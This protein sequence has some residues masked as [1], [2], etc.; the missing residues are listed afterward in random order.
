MTKTMYLIKSDSEKDRTQFCSNVESIVVSMATRQDI[1]GLKYTIT[2]QQPPKLTV[3]PFHQGLLASISVYGS[4]GA[5]ETGLQEMPGFV[6]AFEVEEAYPIAYDKTW[7]DNEPTPG[8]NL[9][10]LFKKRPDIDYATFLDRWHNGHT[11]LS[12]EIHP[13]WNYSR[14][15]VKAQIAGN[16]AFDGIV[17][18]HFRTR[19]DLLNPIKFFGNALRMIP[20]M[21]RVYADVKRFIDYP[22]IETYLATEYHVKSLATPS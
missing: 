22:T 7:P 9:V 10:T 2:A 16:E 19:S 1:H 18:E 6:G 8:V 4:L 3:I 5:K 17:E 15:V 21:W 11:P 13:M 20:N 14:N 12:L